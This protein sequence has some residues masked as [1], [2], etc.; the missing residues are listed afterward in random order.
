MMVIDYYIYFVFTLFVFEFLIFFSRIK[1][2]SKIKI[3]IVQ[4]LY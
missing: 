2:E 1:G 4:L 3:F